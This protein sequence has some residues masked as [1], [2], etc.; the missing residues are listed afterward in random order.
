M[1]IGL[2]GKAGAGK[3]S[4]GQLLADKLGYELYAYADPLKELCKEFIPELPWWG[5]KTE[6]ET[7]Y[8]VRDLDFNF[9][10][11]FGSNIGLR[12][13]VLHAINVYF[14]DIVEN[15]EKISAREILQ[16][17]GTE[18][19]RKMQ[20]NYFWVTL[21]Q[22][23][24]NVVITDVRFVNE[25]VDYNF[26]IVC[27]ISESGDSHESEKGIDDAYFDLVLENKFSNNPKQQLD[28]LTNLILEKLANEKET[29]SL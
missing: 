25:L 7:E 9:T 28:K 4:I 13:D 3:D 5:T 23:K 22:S 21:G 27:G 8:L 18:I 11:T 17:V 6:K 2:H 24:D 14:L 10:V 15:K 19:V 1:R 26:K 12:W 16:Y 20:G 29:S